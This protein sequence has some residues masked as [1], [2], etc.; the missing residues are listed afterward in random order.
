MA[1]YPSPGD[2]PTGSSL[3]EVKFGP[4]TMDPT[5]LVSE[6]DTVAFVAYD[7]DFPY[8]RDYAGEISRADF[9]P[10]FDDSSYSTDGTRQMINLG[11]G[12]LAVTTQAVKQSANLQITGDLTLRAGFMA[13]PGHTGAQVLTQYEAAGETEATNILYMLQVNYSTGEVRYFAEKN[14]GTNLETIWF[15]PGGFVDG[16]AY[17][18]S[19]TRSAGGSCYAYVNGSVLGR[20]DSTTNMVDAGDG[21]ATGGTPTGGSSSSLDVGNTQGPQLGLIHILDA[22]KSAGDEAS[23]VSSITGAGWSDDQTNSL[24]TP[25]SVYTSFAAETGSVVCLKPDSAEDL[26]LKDFDGYLDTSTGGD[27]TQEGDLYLLGSSEWA[28]NT[29]RIDS[30]A[31]SNLQ[32][33]G[34]LTVRISSVYEGTNSAM[35]S[36]L[37][38][39]ETEATN[40]LYE[41]QFVSSTSIRYVHERGAG[42]N[43]TVTWTISALEDAEL[44]F[45]SLVREDQG[46]GTCHVRLY[47]NGVLI[48]VTGV[49][50]S[51]SNQTTYADG[52]NPTGG[53]SGNLY[54]G[55]NGT[56]DSPKSWKLFQVFNVA[57]SAATELAAAQ[58]IGLG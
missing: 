20:I 14:A 51:M 30:V 41:L 7:R 47:E 34:S 32:I 5:V 23:F 40:V 33:T 17:V 18:V 45:Y 9:A 10:S 1:T 13:E 8:I 28:E 48:N 3:D 39:G 26:N 35:Y 19:I 58:A 21:E 6:S 54:I 49:T 52:S 56:G 53:T 43:D 15:F 2:V 24:L 16:T 29:W 57:N 25:D 42:V 12:D 31:K 44:R 38:S 11:D 4:W 36:H 37:A 46:D 55:N 50:G 22:E 27:I